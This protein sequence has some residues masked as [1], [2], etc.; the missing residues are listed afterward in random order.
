MTSSDCYELSLALT[1]E[2]KYMES[3]RLW[4]MEALRKYNLEN[5]SY[6]FTKEDIMQHI[7]TADNNLGLRITFIF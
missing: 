1:A 6:T 7:T 3:G 4:M 5:I 2:R